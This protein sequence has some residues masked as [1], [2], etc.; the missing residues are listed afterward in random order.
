MSLQQFLP[1]GLDFCKHLERHHGLEERVIFPF[2]ARKMPAFR[3]ELELLTQHK[4]IHAGLHSLQEY[5]Q[6]TEQG[7]R[8][9]R[10]QEM[11]EIMD[12]FGT[13]LWEHLKDEVEQLGA[14]N[15]RKYWALEEMRQIPMYDTEI[16][17]QLP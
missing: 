14:E 3:K 17:V 11:K 6:E 5:L 15:M 10:M 12:S 2:L 1:F 7:A 8:D 9:F 4:Q 13:V 16:K